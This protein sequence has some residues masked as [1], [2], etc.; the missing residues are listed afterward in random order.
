MERFTMNERPP[1]FLRRLLSTGLLFLLLTA[2]GCASAAYERARRKNT[3]EAYEDFLSHHPDSDQALEARQRL[4]KLRYDQVRFLRTEQAYQQFIERYPDS[5]YAPEIRRELEA[6]RYKRA[7]SRRTIEDY[8]TYLEYHPSGAHADEI[9][10]LYEER[11]W[12]EAEQKNTIEAFQAFLEKA[13]LESSKARAH[14]KIE[15]LAYQEATTSDTPEAYALFLQKYGKSTFAKEAKLRYEEASYRQAVLE[16]TKDAYLAFLR[17]F[18]QSRHAKAVRD[19]LEFL[20]AIE[21][22]SVDALR[23][24]LRDH[25]D[26]TFASD[27][28][29]KIEILDQR[30]ASRFST[31]GL[32]I[33]VASQKE[34][35]SIIFGRIFGTLEAK[36]GKRGYRAVLVENVTKSSLKA[37]LFVKYAERPGTRYGSTE[38]DATFGTNVTATISFRYKGSAQ[39]IWTTYVSGT[40]RASSTTLEARE[41]RLAALED[42]WNNLDT[43][44]LPYFTPWNAQATICGRVRLSSLPFAV[45][46]GR[47]RF[48]EEVGSFK[49]QLLAGDEL[50]ITFRNMLKIFDIRQ[51]SRLLPLAELSLPTDDAND[52]LLRNNILYVSGGTGGLRIVDVREP[53]APTEVRKVDVVYS[54]G[55]DIYKSYLYLASW[56]DGLQIYDAA[57]NGRPRF[58]SSLSLGAPVKD[59]VIHGDHAFVTVDEVGIVVLD[60]SDPLKPSVAAKY[61]A[62]NVVRIA[63]VGNLLALLEGEGRLA[64]LHL[65]DVVKPAIPRRVSLLRSREFSGPRDIAGTRTHLYIVSSDDSGGYVHSD[66]KVVKISDPTNPKI[67]GAVALPSPETVTVARGFAYVSGLELV[68]VDIAAFR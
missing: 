57:E 14:A 34:D 28:E 52:L 6:L 12:E 9:L 26:N 44:R 23:Q 68:T 46:A 10:A 7:V 67:V 35:R 20:T 39:P 36:L 45:T 65:V 51:C 24:F 41:L 13:R 60:L 29:E 54:G 3:V 37:F 38:A 43:Y 42:F 33:E 11:L 58:L 48:W 63:L 22:G 25:P 49:D 47:D 61:S 2:V 16:D 1:R 62:P 55:L 53:H 40:N 8:E 56:K 66:L 64:T 21:F 59:V 4:E 32:Q 31:V 30:Q 17:H 15:E 18:P 19:R 50:Y 27:V 5:P